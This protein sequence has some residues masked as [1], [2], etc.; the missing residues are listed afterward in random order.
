[1]EN[2]VKMMRKKTK[3]TG[4]VVLSDKHVVLKYVDE[5]EHCIEFCDTMEYFFERK[6]FIERSNIFDKETTCFCFWEMKKWMGPNISD[7]SCSKVLDRLTQI[8]PFRSLDLEVDAS[9]LTESFGTTLMTLTSE[10][11]R[12]SSID[13]KGN[14]DLKHLNVIMDSADKR[15]EFG[16]LDFEFPLNFHHDKAFHFYTIYYGDARWV[17]TRHLCSLRNSRNVTLRNLM[18]TPKDIN[19]FI[20]YWINSEYDMFKSMRLLEYSTDVDIRTVLKD[21]VALETFLFERK[22]Y[23]IS[24]K[25]PTSRKYSVLG[26]GFGYDTLSLL[27]L[28]PREAYS[29]HPAEPPL[30]EYK[31]LR[32]L[33]EKTELEKELEKVEGD[34]DGMEE[35][36][37][38]LVKKYQDLVEEFK[39]SSIQP[40]LDLSLVF[41]IV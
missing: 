37:Q 33:N 35:R 39:F 23:L 26:I 20:K 32:Y 30:K 13:L 6:D 9:N 18:L 31:V 2:V 17:R 7:N 14:I 3:L 15:S 34:Q 16:V 10:L 21:V 41:K 8:S 24:A 29:R 28:T 27:A 38:N 4:F 5:S 36:V 12:F 1:M 25:Y 40:T 19:C 11:K 22:F